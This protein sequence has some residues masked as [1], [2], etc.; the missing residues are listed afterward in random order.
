MT[1]NN[2]L[3]TGEQFDGVLDRY[4]LRARYYDQAVG[5]FGRLDTWNGLD[6]NPITLN[7]YLYGNNDSVLMVDPTGKFGL[8]VAAAL[9]IPSSLTVAVTVRL[10]T[11]AAPI[12][13]WFDKDWTPDKD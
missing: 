10:A 5:R 6:T 13:S 9:Y 2:Y 1:D 8:A 4:Y 7:K 11:F 3:F 12:N